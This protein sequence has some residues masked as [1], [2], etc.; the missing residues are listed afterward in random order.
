MILPRPIAGLVPHSGPMCLLD[1]VTHADAAGL[2]AMVTPAHDA[3]FMTPDGLPGWIGLE[4]MAQAVAAWGYLT[5]DTGQ[6]E[7][8]RKGLL[9]GASRLQ[10]FEHYLQ[11]GTTYRVDITPGFV[12]DNGLG[13]F[14]GAIFKTDAR[15]AEAT[16]KIFQPSDPAALTDG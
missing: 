16:L 12:A 14:D 10:L 4:W 11:P 9:L 1:S 3:M 13:T 5:A 2:S 7:A 6:E 8:P 15:V